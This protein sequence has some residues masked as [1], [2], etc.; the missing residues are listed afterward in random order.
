MRRFV[1][2]ITGFILLT[3]LFLVSCRKESDSLDE[4][5]L[6]YYPFNGNVK[7]AGGNGNHGVDYSSG[8]YV[9]GKIGKALNFNGT[10]DYV[11]LSK[12]IYS[13]DGLTFSFWIKSRG[14]SGS[15][16]NGVI[17]GKYNMTG[18]NRCFIVYSFGAN[19]TR[20]DNRL[21]AAFYKEGFSSGFHDNVKS[22]FEPAELLAFPSNPSLW[23]I[24]DPKRIETGVWTHCVIN[25]TEKNLEVWLNGSLC[26][27]KQREYSSYYD[28]SYESV[29]IGNNPA[30]GG[31]I[32][33]HF[34][35]VIDELRIYNRE[36]THEEIN[37]LSSQR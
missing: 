1:F 5:L 15:E 32:N 7:D 6:F 28:N 31:G 24:S 2:S 23:T 16:N 34:N 21:S 35:G 8:N 12:S 26:V 13:G 20:A 36:L 10:T 14:A 9:A 37:K 18:N 29:Y 27:S 11:Q 4:G 33:N 17:I 25:V 22:Y 19:E 30:M 3:F